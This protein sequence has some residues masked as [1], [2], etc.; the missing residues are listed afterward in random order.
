[1]NYI[2]RADTFYSPSKSSKTMNP[3]K[4]MFFLFLLIS[5]GIFAQAQNKQQNVVCSDVL[6]QQISSVKSLG[7]NVNAAYQHNLAAA[8]LSR[9]GAVAAKKS[10]DD[11]YA[12]YLAELQNQLTANAGDSPLH[13]AL[14]NEIALVK[15]LQAASAA[16]GK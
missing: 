10:L 12:A 3:K 16:Q 1:M 7:D 14:V 13:T 11:S 15:K 5:G 2:C 6:L 8:T 4:I 9:T